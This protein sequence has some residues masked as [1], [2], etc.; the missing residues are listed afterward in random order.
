MM[1]NLVEFYDLIHSTDAFFDL[2]TANRFQKVVFRFLKFYCLLS[3]EA[4]SSGS[5]R[6]QV[7]MKHHL[8]AHMG[9]RHMDLNPKFG[10]TYSDESMVG[11]MCKIVA[12]SLDG[13]HHKVHQRT[14]LTKYLLWL[15]IDLDT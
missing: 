5:V 3:D 14:A 4:I 2:E 12:S 10:S 7:V 1:E 9:L 13:N 6:W 11:R 8:M 15:I